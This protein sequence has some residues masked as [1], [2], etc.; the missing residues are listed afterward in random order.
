MNLEYNIDPAVYVSALPERRVFLRARVSHDNHVSCTKAQAVEYAIMC[1]EDVLFIWEEKYPKDDRP[2]KA[3]EA[4]RAWLAEPTEARKEAAHAAANAAYAVY[5]AYA[6]TA[7]AA[8]YSAAAA[9][10]NAAE[11]AYSCARAAGADFSFINYAESCGL[12]ADAI[13]KMPQQL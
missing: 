4:A 10:K 9:A 2:R 5:S 6:A 7:T 1:A 13:R 11:A 3:I 12:S 8:A